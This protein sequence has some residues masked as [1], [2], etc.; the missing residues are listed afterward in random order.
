MVELIGILAGIF[1]T[2]GAIPQLVKAYRT[3]S[4]GDV[5]VWMFVTL[6]TGVALWTVY[7]IMEKDWPILIT[8]AISCVLNATMV[9]YCYRYR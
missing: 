9:Y 1:T 2:A 6:L 5:S 7:G 8:N 3:K 4:V